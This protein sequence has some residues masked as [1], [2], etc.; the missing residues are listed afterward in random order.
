MVCLDFA[1][2]DNLAKEIKADYDFILEK[3][4]LKQ[5]VNSFG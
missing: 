5:Q 3:F 2:D 1:K 4:I